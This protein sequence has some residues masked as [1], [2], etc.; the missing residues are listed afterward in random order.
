MWTIFK[1]FID[2]VATLLLFY[3]LGFCPR[4]MWDSSSPTR[5]QTFTPCIGRQSLN[6]GLPEKSWDHDAYT[7]DWTGQ[8]WRQLHVGGQ[9]SPSLSRFSSAVPRGP[10]DVAPFWVPGQSVL[11]K[12]HLFSLKKYLGMDDKWHGCITGPGATKQALLPGDGW[13]W[14]IWAVFLESPTFMLS[15]LSCNFRSVTHPKRMR[16]SSSF[17]QRCSWC[18]GRL[19]LSCIYL[20]IFRHRSKGKC[21]SMVP[22]WHPQS[23]WGV[24]VNERSKTTWGINGECNIQP[25]TCHQSVSLQWWHTLMW[26]H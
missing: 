12:K 25:D 19:T 1:V 2:F 16:M 14:Q 5:D 21:M 9:E 24:Y 11:I 3:V 7:S 18:S 4:G 10:P 26:F 22:T 17:A 23:R 15:C 20:L 6:P 8:P 13:V